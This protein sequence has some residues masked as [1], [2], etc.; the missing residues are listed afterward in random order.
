MKTKIPLS[1]M[2]R[3]E[4]LKFFKRSDYIAVIGFVCIG[5]IFALN[6][7]GDSYTGVQ[8]QNALFWVTVQ[9]LTTTTLFIG[10]VIMS[11]IGTQMLASEIDN[12][13]ILL[14]TVRI[15]NRKKMYV[16]K[17]LALLLIGMLF[18][19]A[20]TVILFIIYFL[21]GDADSVYISGKLAGNNVVDLL[22]VLFM[23]YLFAFLLIP[24]M[25]LCLGAWMKPLVTVIMAFVVTLVCNN[26]GTLPV[27]KYFNP[28]Y[29]I[30]RLANDVAATTDVVEISGSDR[31]FCV[32]TQLALICAY[33]LLFHFLG[34]QKLKER[35]LS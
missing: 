35:D 32:L 4:L 13:S 34:A 17:S 33:C 6:M 16:G 1:L 8:N 21:A 2:I 12:K 23:N 24:Q 5:L 14:F 11:F 31:V 30:V 10:P 7:R 3:T 18:F 25:A 28:M 22:L 26:T 9:M 15:R 27:I 19:L 29:Y 20:S